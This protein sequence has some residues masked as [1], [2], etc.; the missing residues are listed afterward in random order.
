MD[1]FLN[2]THEV[3]DGNEKAEAIA[4][5]HSRSARFKY[6][7]KAL[8][9][10]YPTLRPYDPVYLSGLPQ[11]MSGIWVV[12]SLVHKFNI[13]IPY[14]MEAILGSNDELLLNKPPTTP[15]D[16]SKSTKKIKIIVPQDEDDPLVP[17]I[18]VDP[19]DFYYETPKKV[20]V[21]AETDS[22]CCGSGSELSIWVDAN[23]DKSPADTSHLYDY[24]TP[25]LSDTPAETRWR[26]AR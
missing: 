18:A 20:V 5:A 2:L 4:R 3:V 15:T 23:L 12:I 26:V 17:I 1:N 24:M 8:L 25:K 16:I 13:G 22:C 21:P 9:S 7:A 14:S 6:R 11:N 19:K 10:G